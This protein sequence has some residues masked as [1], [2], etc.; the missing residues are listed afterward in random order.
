MVEYAASKKTR[1]YTNLKCRE[2][3]SNIKIRNDYLSRHQGKCKRCQNRDEPFRSQYN[4]MLSNNKDWGGSLLFEEFLEFTKINNCHYCN[5]SIVWYPYRY[6]WNSD[7]TKSSDKIKYNLDR[8]DSFK[9]Y[10]KDNLVVCCERCNYGKS[11]IFSYEEWFGMTAYFR[12][13]GN[14]L[15]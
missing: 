12:A 14:A 6:R 4:K 11:N 8:K 10:D 2:C 3:D 9:G 13:S 7:G 5:S 15:H 1:K